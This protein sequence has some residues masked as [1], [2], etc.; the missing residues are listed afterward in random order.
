MVEC[1]LNVVS[2][3]SKRLRMPRSTKADAG[4]AR[5]D[6]KE[7]PTLRGAEVGA[8]TLPLLGVGQLPD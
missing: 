6:Q 1:L 5:R 3:L 2:D 7:A 8:K 4:E